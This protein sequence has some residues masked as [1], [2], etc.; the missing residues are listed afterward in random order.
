MVHDR[1]TAVLIKQRPSRLTKEIATKNRLA[2]AFDG[3][4]TIGLRFPLS[5]DI[6]TAFVSGPP[7]YHE[8]P[9]S[10]RDAMREK[11]DMVAQQVVP[12]KCSLTIELK[13]F[14][15]ECPGR[16][17]KEVWIPDF[18]YDRSWTGLLPVDPYNDFLSGRRKALAHGEG[19][20]G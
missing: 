17:S 1:R 13:A 5:P 2:F 8:L 10:D 16:F 12:L 6:E 3:A 9:A 4:R 19:C 20:R 18:H 11:S 14:T 15:V 7:C